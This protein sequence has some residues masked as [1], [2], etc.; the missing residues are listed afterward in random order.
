MKNLGNSNIERPSK[1]ILEGF[2]GLDVSLVYD[3]LWNRFGIDTHLVG[4]RPMF[5]FMKDKVY[6]R[7]I[8]VQKICH[9]LN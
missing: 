2:K 1:N 9:I 4:I 7:V 6:V 3:T 8:H 5:E